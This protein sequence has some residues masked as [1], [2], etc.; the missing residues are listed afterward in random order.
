ML[1]LVAGVD[2]TPMGFAP[3]TPRF[4]SRTTLRAGDLGLSPAEA[5][6]H[7]LPGAAA[8]VGADLTCGTFV[9]GLAYEGG[10]SL[11]VDV[12]TNGEIIARFGEHLLGCATAAGPAFEGS[13]LTQGLRAGDG[14]LSHVRFGSDHS[15]EVEVIGGG[16]PTGICGSAYVDLL[17]AGNRAG[18]LGPTGRF[19]DSWRTSVPD[20]FQGGDYGLEMTLARGQGGPPVTVSELDISRLLQA[21]AAI[22]AGIRTLLRKL[23]LKPQDVKT[24]HLAGGFGMHLDLENAIAAGLLPGFAVDQVQLVGNTSLGGASLAFV[25]SS[26]VE[27]LQRIGE[28]M[29]IVELNMEP[30]F[31]DTYI[32]ELSVPDL[33]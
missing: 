21:K 6:V 18:L 8:Y 23:G 9:S 20:R 29:E 13:G 4:L 19:T 25:D 3:F 14:A 7:L 10:P 2:P 22:A 5:E 28:S 12:G 32:E 24:L 27:E 33:L 15:V 11:L 17:G 16:K 26:V 1:H 31:E 30:G